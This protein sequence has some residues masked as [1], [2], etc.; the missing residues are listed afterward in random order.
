MDQQ[1]FKFKVNY[2]NNQELW[3]VNVDFKANQN[4]RTIDAII[5]H[6][7]FYHPTE[8][9]C[10]MRRENIKTQFVEYIVIYHTCNH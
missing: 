9:Q 10:V 4:K 2:G 7:G 6:M 3:G 8:N 1:I 5:Q